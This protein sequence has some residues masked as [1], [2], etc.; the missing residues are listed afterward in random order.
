MS[1]SRLDIEKF[2]F[3]EARLADEHRY[4]EWLSLWTDD[5]IYWVP[6]DSDDTDPLRQVS[7]IYDNRA[8]LGERIARLKSGTVLAQDPKPRMRRVIS[9]IEIGPASEAE[10]KVESNFVLIEARG[11]G[12]NIWC[13]RSI[14]TLRRQDDNLKM[15]EKKV[16]LVSTGQ[17]MPVLQFLV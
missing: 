5:A 13:G 7:L 4:E 10:V 6:C 17:E 14:H 2:L 16:L 3:R 12:Q 15:A 9:N 11:R 8:R 1:V